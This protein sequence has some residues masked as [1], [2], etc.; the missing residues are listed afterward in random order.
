MRAAAGARVCN[1]VFARI[2]AAGFNEGL[3]RLKF[4]FV[5]H[6]KHQWLKLNP[7]DM[8]QGI[9]SEGER[10]RCSWWSGSTLS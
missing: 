2:F 5:F 6:G 8:R 1:F 7:A 10:C 9:V 3:E 4:R